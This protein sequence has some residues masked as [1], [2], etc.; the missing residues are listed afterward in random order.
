MKVLLLGPYRENIIEFLNTFNDVVIHKEE[1]IEEHELI[2]ENVDY[3][4]SYGYRYIIPKSVVNLYEGKIINLHISFLPWNRGADPN[5]W[6]FLEDTPKGVTIHYIDVGL[7]TGDIIA[8]QRVDFL[9]DETLSSSYQKLTN[10]IESLFKKV[11]PD[12]RMG[13][14]IRF[15]QIGKGSYHNSKEKDKFMHL[16]HGGWD[17]PINRIIRAAK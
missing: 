13:K 5:L 11:W 16:L 6:S 8:Q 9:E 14:S 12:I 1:K 3:I 10:E 7:D 2:K 15:T 17:T 4:I